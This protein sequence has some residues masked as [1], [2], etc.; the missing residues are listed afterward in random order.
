MIY[1]LYLFC[2]LIISCDLPSEANQDCNGDSGGIALLDNCGICS[3]GETNLESCVPD[4]SN[5]KDACD[6]NWKDGECWGGTAVN[7]EC[8]V[9]DGDNLSCSDCFNIPNGN[10]LNDECGVCNGLGMCSCIDD[11]YSCNCCCPIN[12]VLD[13]YGVC[14]NPMIIE[15]AI[16]D[17]CGICEGDIF[18]G[19]NIGD[20]CGCSVDDMIDGCGLCS[21]TGFID[22]MCF[23][24][25]FPNQTYTEDNEE[26]ECNASGS[27]PYE[28]GD[29]LSCANIE[30]EFDICYPDNCG[31]V[32]LADFEGK[33]ILIIYEF[34]W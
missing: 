8:D 3:G 31:D 6:G 9:C 20:H 19:S 24:N 12:E 2:F 4:C 16:S 13:C 14:I 18:F 22:C 34:D 30:Q 23:N 15:P 7:D 21:G 29:Q 11:T 10:A 5:S 25:T 17:D 1:F 28:I 26:F 32:K 27:A 33:N